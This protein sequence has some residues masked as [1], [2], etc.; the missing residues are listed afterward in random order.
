MVLTFTK[1]AWDDYLYWQKLDKKIVKKIN[2]LLKDIQRNPFDGL[3]K[4]ERLK[5]DLAGY[6]SYVELPVTAGLSVGI[7]VSARLRQSDLSGYI[8]LQ[9]WDGTTWR[10][11]DSATISDLGYEKVRLNIVLAN[12]DSAQKA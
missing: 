10:S 5:Y 1:N 2:G 11:T 3:G 6:W 12:K 8:Y 9:E 4:P 7:I